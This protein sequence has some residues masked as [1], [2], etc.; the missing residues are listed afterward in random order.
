[1]VKEE[2]KKADP[3]QVNIK[4][5]TFV[6]SAYS[7]AV[8]V[9]VTDNDITLEFIYINPRSKTEGEIVSRVTLPRVAGEGLAK[10]IGDT[11]LQ[12]EANKRKGEDGTN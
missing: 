8:S 1:M 11:V 7:Q 9:T 3:T 6:G 5:G 10:A 12:H 4:S 2:V